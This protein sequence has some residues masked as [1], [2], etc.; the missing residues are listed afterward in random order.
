MSLEQN[1]AVLV[2]EA[3]PG[4][5]AL[6]CAFNQIMAEETEGRRLD[7]ETLARG[8]RAVLEDRAKGFYLVAE[9]AGRVIGQLMVTFEWSDWRDGLFWWIQSVY[10]APEARRAGVYRALHERVVELARE[11]GRSCGV[12]LYVEVE[13]HAARATYERLGMKQCRY[14][15]YELEL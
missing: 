5:H 8:V 14:H 15:M 4:D 3:R 1:A 13:N 6:L 12:R 11:S 2:R 9:R 10:V 7:E